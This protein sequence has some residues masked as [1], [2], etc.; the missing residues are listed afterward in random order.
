M[1]NFHSIP[2]EVRNSISSVDTRLGALAGC[3]HF[4]RMAL[5][6]IDRSGASIVRG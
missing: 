6:N 1:S 3:V 2:W 5:R 4:I